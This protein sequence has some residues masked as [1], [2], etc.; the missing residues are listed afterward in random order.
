MCDTS[1]IRATVAFSFGGEPWN[2][3]PWWNEPP[4]AF[5][6]TETTSSSS[7]SGAA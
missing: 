5:T 1:A 2:V 4:P 7:P 3:S 6:A